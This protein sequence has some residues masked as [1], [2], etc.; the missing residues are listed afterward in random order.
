MFQQNHKFKVGFELDFDDSSAFGAN[1]K[2]EFSH[3]VEFYKL[4][5]KINKS[6]F[7]AAFLPFTF[8]S[9]FHTVY[10][11]AKCFFRSILHAEYRAATDVYALMFLTDVID[12]IVIIFG[13]W[14]FGVR[15]EFRFHKLRKKEHMLLKL[16]WLKEGSTF[17]CL[18]D[19]PEHGLDPDQIRT[20]SGPDQDHIRNRSG[21]DQDQIR[22]KSEPEKDQ[23]RTPWHLQ[24]S[25]RFCSGRVQIRFSDQTF[26]DR[27][28]QNCWMKLKFQDC[29]L[30][31]RTNLTKEPEPVPH[32]RNRI[33]FD[34]S[35]V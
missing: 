17:S 11:P 4:K 6:V 20:R 22:T 14:A 29:G 19:G 31:L 23:I 33:G 15:E 9:S 32:L 27:V 26:F 2:P 21:P 34:V 8:L 12:F 13:F 35:W 7:E 1:S 25:E 3:V 16:K 30:N 24:C 5:E 28:H 10:H 18:M